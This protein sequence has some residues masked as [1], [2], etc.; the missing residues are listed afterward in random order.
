VDEALRVGLAEIQGLVPPPDHPFGIPV[1]WH[2][3]ASLNG[4]LPPADFKALVDRYG[5]GWFTSGCGELVI[6]EV[7][8]PD[9]TYLEG[10]AWERENLLARQRRLP[11]YVPSWPIYPADGADLPI[12]IVEFVARWLRADLGLPE[13]G[14]CEVGAMGFQPHQKHAPWHGRTEDVEIAFAVG[15]PGVKTFSQDWHE[16]I[17]DMIRPATLTFLGEYADA[18][19]PLHA[20]MGVRYR[21][22]DE[23][24]VVA[25]IE[26]LAARLGTSVERVTARD[27]SVGWPGQR[28]VAPR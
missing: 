9:R 3:F 13:A 28:T 6:D 24:A 14:T 25:A 12:G 27:G 20:E 8:H 7:G 5:T 21:T 10:N 23:G 26:R 18:H 4:F 15:M 16:A 22:S 2:E 17:G 19:T 11:V 1:D